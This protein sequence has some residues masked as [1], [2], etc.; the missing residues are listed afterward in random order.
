MPPK[1]STRSLEAKLSRLA[2][3]REAP[4]TAELHDELAKHLTDKSAHVVAR[5][6]SVIEARKFEL[7]ADNVEAE[8][9]RFMMDPKKLD[10]GCIA[11]TA[12]VTCL[13][14]LEQGSAEVFLKSL[15]HIQLEPSFGGP[16]DTAVELR[17]Q[18]AFGL[19]S[20]GYPDTVLE[21]TTALAD[22][23]YPVRQAAVRALSSLGRIEVEPVLRLKAL[24]GDPEPQV[25]SETLE[26]LL[27]LSPERSL[28]FVERYLDASDEAV[29]EAAVL[30]LGASRCVGAF[31][32]L[33]SRL[34]RSFSRSS[35]TRTLL[36]AIAMLRRDN[37]IA[38]LLNLVTEGPRR[39]A[40][41][42]L[43]ALALH[44]YDRALSER[45]ASAV[46]ARKEDD[47]SEIYAEE[48]PSGSGSSERL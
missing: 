43:R 46:E 13:A 34:D 38:F 35:L 27:V 36:L 39:R 14:S 41:D 25:L 15:R 40:E 5:A 12:I 20:T 19:T 3:L 24:H 44:R 9:E 8:F 37:A 45:I 10:K 29:G 21:L 1:R 48:F 42:A 17:S 23:A 16:V 30:A 11:K 4:E 26:A 28:S 18:S 33:T 2:E 31:E 6:A 22:E 7:L 47:L 32:L